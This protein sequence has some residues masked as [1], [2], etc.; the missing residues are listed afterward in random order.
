[1]LMTVQELLAYLPQ[2]ADVPTASV[3]AMLNVATDIAQRYCNRQFESACVVERHSINCKNRYYLRRTPICNI[4]RVTV[5]S[6]D[7][8]V[9]ADSQGYVTSFDSAHTNLTEDCEHLWDVGYKANP[10]NGIIEVTDN[11]GYASSGLH[12]SYLIQFEYTGGY[13]QI[14]SMLKYAVAQVVE[15]MYS[16]SKTD[17]VFRSEKIGDYSYTKF[18]DVSLTARGSVVSDLLAPFVRPS[19]NGV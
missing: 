4:D 1:M 12:R 11:I 15:Q 16:R 2:L 14:P 9:L 17:P 7:T 18:D 10:A 13:E 6:L 5:I 8:P 19:V 3:Q